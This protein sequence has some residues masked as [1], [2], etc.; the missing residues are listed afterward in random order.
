[1][2]ETIICV[3]RFVVVGPYTTALKLSIGRLIACIQGN[4]GSDIT[5]DMDSASGTS[6]RSLEY[7]IYRRTHL[8][9]K[10]KLIEMRRQQ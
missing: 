8:H 5:P 9:T 7:L 3:A 1:M 10:D 6:V 2:R 4:I